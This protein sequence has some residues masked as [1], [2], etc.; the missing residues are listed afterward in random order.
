MLGWVGCGTFRQDHTSRLFSSEGEGKRGCNYLAEPP[1]GCTRAE[2]FPFIVRCLPEGRTRQMTPGLRHCSSHVHFGL[3]RGR[4]HTPATNYLYN[5]TS[6]WKRGQHQTGLVSPSPFFT[7]GTNDS[8]CCESL[9]MLPLRE[10]SSILWSIV[11]YEGDMTHLK[12][13]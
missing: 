1:S 12:R 3:C 6:C 8:S 10:F 9:A 11:A 13:V 5:L 7:R 2:W 4:A